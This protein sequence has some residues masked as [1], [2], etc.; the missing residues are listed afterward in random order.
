MKSRTRNWEAQPVITGGVG[1]DAVRPRFNKRMH[2]LFL[3]GLNSTARRSSDDGFQS[4][5]EIRMPAHIPN[6]GRIPRGT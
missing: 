1:G 5:T 6:S 3:S 2:I 4:S